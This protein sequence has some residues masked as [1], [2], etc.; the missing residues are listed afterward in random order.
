M[1]LMDFAD[2][3]LGSILEFFHVPSLDAPAARGDLVLGQPSACMIA[4]ASTCKRIRRLFRLE[5][6]RAQLERDTAFARD[7]WITACVRAAQG[8]EHF[9]YMTQE[10]E[11]RMGG[12]AVTFYYRRVA[13]VPLAGR[14]TVTV[15][16]TTPRVSLSARWEHPRSPTSARKREADG[17]ELLERACTCTRAAGSA[18][19]LFAPAPTECSKDA[20]LTE[21]Y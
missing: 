13:G 10:A 16:L 19:S 5:A 18:H 9:F 20:G 7:S 21:F 6:L 14:G 1:L 17:R 3:T 2:D 4:L 11:M 12:H 15:R 8:R